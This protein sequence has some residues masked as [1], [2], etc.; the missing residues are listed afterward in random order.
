M[1]TNEIGGRRRNALAKPTRETLDLATLAERAIQSHN[2]KVVRAGAE[3]REAMRRAV[4][5]ASEMDALPATDPSADAP[6]A[7]GTP[8]PSVVQ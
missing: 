8:G 5:A 7:Q 3:F 2:V 6:A 4:A 1:S